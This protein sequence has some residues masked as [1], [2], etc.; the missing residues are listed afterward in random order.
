MLFYL[1]LL[2]ISFVHG[3]LLA[4]EDNTLRWLKLSRCKV[5]GL[6]FGNPSAGWCIGMYLSSWVRRRLTAPGGALGPMPS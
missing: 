2:K 5:L 4:K 6:Y 3:E 1:Q